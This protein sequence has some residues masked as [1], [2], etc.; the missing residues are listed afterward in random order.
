MGKRTPFEDYPLRNRAIKG[1]KCYQLN[2]RT[3]KLIGAMAVEDDS[4]IMLITNEGTIIQLLCSQIRRLS[5]YATGVRLINLAEGMKVASVEKVHI[6]E[7]VTEPDVV[8]EIDDDIIEEDEDLVEG[9][10]YDDVEDEEDTG[11]D[12]E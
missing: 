3:G 9:Q 11:E 4:E 2:E 1:V 5:R 12:E 10:E 7:D 6:E 8:D